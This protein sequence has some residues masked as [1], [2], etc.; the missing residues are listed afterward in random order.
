MSTTP[1]TRQNASENDLHDET[2]RIDTPEG[3]LGV[4]VRRPSTDGPFPVVLMFHHG[5]G[6]DDGT[7]EAMEIFA[8]AG[9]FVVCPDR[10]YREGPWITF[11]AAELMS[12]GP[13]SEVMGRFFGLLSRTTDEM[14]ARDAQAVFERVAVDPAARKGKVGCIG[15]CVGARSVIRTMEDHPEVAAGILLHPGQC[16]VDGPDSPHLRVA[17]L[18]G[19]LYIA[20][21][22][23]DRM[24]SVEQ[25]QPL[26]DAASRLGEN[27]RVDIHDGADHGFAVPG[28]GYH[29]AAADRSYAQALDLLAR[30]LG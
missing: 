6:L 11:N 9:Y 4:R 2:W 8:R 22:A 13:D 27:A 25:N 3:E 21:G 19:N 10:Y 12:G 28:P 29:A 18:T 23:Q 7:V 17:A 20:L 14:M 24:S 30:T 5:P 26:I 1:P 15:Y 16:V